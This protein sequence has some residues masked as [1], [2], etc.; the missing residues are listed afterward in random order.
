MK[1]FIFLLIACLTT[2]GAQSQT[3]ATAQELFNQGKYEEAKPLLLK[4]VKSQPS[5][6]KYNLWYGICCLKTNNPQSAVKYL[7]TAVRRRTPSGQFYLAQ[8][9][10]AN[11]QYELAIE[12]L[13]DYITALERRKKP[14]E[15]AE[16]QLQKSKN[17]LRMLK[18][19]EQ[20]TFIDSIIVPKDHFL[21]AYKIS[22]ESG[23]LYTFQDLFG[24]GNNQPGTVYK[25]QIGNKLYYGMTDENGL[26]NI[27]LKSKNMESWS[28]GTKLPDNINASGNTNYPFVMSDGTTIYYASDGEGSIGGYDIFVTR[29]NTYSDNYLMPENIG[30]PFNSPYNDYMYVIDEFNNLGWFATDRYQP[31]DSVCVYVFVPNQAKHTY[32]YESME[33][34]QAVNLAKI[35]S[36]K[37]TWENEDV[38]NEALTRLSAAS[39]PKTA[40]KKQHDFV[41]IINDQNTYYTE[42]DFKSSE[43]LELFKSFQQKKKDLEQLTKRLEV[44]R[45]RYSNGND[46]QKKEMAPGILDLEKRIKELS[47]DLNDLNRLI[48]NTEIISLR[49]K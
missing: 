17:G 10:D 33:P 46:T 2:A 12:T 15:E 35:H 9:Y 20:V 3:T 29:Y 14:T 8:A 49:K 36:I 6:G 27:H 34:S 21:D 37:A 24:Q 18:G 23:N 39:Q 40:K 43:A 19:I 45:E 5:N 44:S 32:N 48:R 11:Y 13:E 22:E 38:I 28:N 25:N 41:F 1:K 47:A 42:K 7:K 30:M 16:K 26:L 31:A 4:Q